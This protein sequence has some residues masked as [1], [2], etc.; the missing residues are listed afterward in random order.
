MKR[1]C[2]IT[3]AG[4][5]IGKEFFEEITNDKDLK[6]DEF[7]VIARSRD[8]LNA[9]TSLTDIPVKVLPL[10]LSKRESY[11]TYRRELDAEKARVGLLINCAGF[12]KFGSTLDVKYEENLGMIDLNVTGTV[13]LDMIS[14]KYMEKG[15]GIINIASV[16]AYQ[17]IPYINTYGAT[18]A[19]VLNFTRG[20]AMEM[21]KKGIHVMAVCP[22]WT[23]TD[24]FDRAID[25]ERD[26]VVKKYVAMYEPKQ[27]VSRALSDYKKG[28]PVSLFGFMTKLQLIAVKIAPT[29]LVMRIWM[30]QQKLK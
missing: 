22:F 21:K 29:G 24:F 10:D 2:V 19:F 7:W 5:G 16:A 8:K 11:D 12:G 6:F 25:P 17:P 9:L 15:D 20:F 23:K 30:R 3:G 1:I 18:K 26:K 4:S 13:A 27:I 28:K 14:A